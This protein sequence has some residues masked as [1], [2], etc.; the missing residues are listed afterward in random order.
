[1]CGL[2]DHVGRRA[3]GRWW[4]PLLLGLLVFS[5]TLPARAGGVEYPLFGHFRAAAGTIEIWL[6][7][8]VDN[9]YPPVAEKQFQSLFP[10]FSCTIPEVL[11]MSGGCAAKGTAKGPQHLLYVSLARPD[12]RDGLL[13]VPGALPAGLPPGAPLHIAFTWRDRDMRLYV[14]GQLIGARQQAALFPAVP[15]GA[16]LTIGSVRSRPAPIILHAV[17]FSCVARPEAE[18]AQA[19]P[20]ADRFT[21]LLDVFDQPQAVSADE[22]TTPAV[23]SPLAGPVQGQVSGPW[24]FAA[25]AQ[26]PGL[27]FT[28][29]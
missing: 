5:T 13:P 21:L 17:R 22:R 1:M 11:N 12:L 9:L 6:T 16:A 4:L 3:G 19:T 7:P 10:L 8:Q 23:S 25:D 29:P 28:Q 27:A 18:L 2:T 26:H 14:N 15:P 20:R 24:H